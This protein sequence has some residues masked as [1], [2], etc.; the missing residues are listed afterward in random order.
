MPPPEEET[1]PVTGLT[2]G[3][4][5]VHRALGRSMHGEVTDV[6]ENRIGEP[7][8]I[9]RLE[10]HNAHA[11]RTSVAVVRLIGAEALGFAERGD[12]VEV[13]GKQRKA[14]MAASRAVNHTTG[15]TY[16]GGGL[17][18]AAPF[19]I[20]LAIAMIAAAVM[21]LLALHFSGPSHAAVGAPLRAFAPH[22]SHWLVG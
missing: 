9:L 2:S 4:E 10:Q 20:L 8:V 19:M 6:S 22:V 14:Y 1:R 7:V 21:V 5:S 12:R 11:G 17:R 15:A 18:R 13:T 3:G 16:A